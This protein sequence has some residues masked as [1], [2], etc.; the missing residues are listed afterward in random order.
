MAN[1][2]QCPEPCSRKELPH[3]VREPI[4]PS[5]LVEANSNPPSAASWDVERQLR[6]L[7]AENH[8]LRKAIEE[9]R[10]CVR[11]LEEKN[12][13]WARLVDECREWLE[14]CERSPAM[15]GQIQAQTQTQLELQL[16]RQE[17][18]F[19]DQQQLLQ[20]SE[21]AKR[22]LLTVL[23]MER[24]DYTEK[25]EALQ[26]ELRE[27]QQKREVELAA[28]VE[29]TKELEVKLAK[30]EDKVADL[31]ASKAKLLEQETELMQTLEKNAA[32]IAELEESDKKLHAELTE[33]HK[34]SEELKTRL[35]ETD[36]KAQALTLSEGRLKT[37][38]GEATKQFQQHSE[39]ISELEKLNGSVKGELDNVKQVAQELETRAAKSERRVAELE[40][41]QAR[42]E[43]DKQGSAAAL[44]LS[45]DRESALQKSLDEM[46]TRAQKA[47][48][49]AS[50]NSKA[51]EGKEAELA[52]TADI[53]TNLR[54][55]IERFKEGSAIADKELESCKLR[56]T[57]A[58]RKAEELEKLAQQSKTTEQAAQQRYEG[59]LASQKNFQADWDSQKLALEKEVQRL[60]Q[61]ISNL[62]AD[63]QQ[64]DKIQAEC[65][66]LRSHM[67]Q[68]QQE[69]MQCR[70]NLEV[71]MQASQRETEAQRQLLEANEQT[72]AL[73]EKLR[74]Q[75]ERVA[76]LERE[77]GTII[78]LAAG[79]SAALGSLAVA[80]TAGGGGSPAASPSA[81]V[82]GLWEDH[83]N[84]A[85][86]QLSLFKAQMVHKEKQT[87]AS[88]HLEKLASAQRLEAS[89]R[90]NA[91]LQDQ[92]EEMQKQVS[93]IAELE[94]K[95][96]RRCQDANEKLAS[97]TRENEELRVSAAV[98]EVKLQKLEEN[99]KAAAAISEELS[100]TKQLLEERNKMLDALHGQIASRDDALMAK[101]SELL[102]ANNQIKELDQ[103]MAALEGKLKAVDSSGNLESLTAECLELRESLVVLE[104]REKEKETQL[105]AAAAK[106]QDFDQTMAAMEERIKQE[107]QEQLLETQSQLAV[108]TDERSALSA[109]VG[110]LRLKL[111]KQ[112][113]EATTGLAAYRS[114]AERLLKENLE[115]RL[116]LEGKLLELQQ[117]Y[118]ADTEQLDQLE[119]DNEDLATRL[120]Q[121]DEALTANERE[122]STAIEAES[123]YFEQVQ[124]LETT[125]LDL[126][127]KMG[128]L[129][130][131]L[132]KKNDI[133]SGLE[134]NFAKER[135]LLDSKV[136]LVRSELQEVKAQLGSKDQVLD[137]AT[138]KLDEK[139]SELEAQCRREAEMVTAASGRIRELEAL[140]VQRDREVE[141][142]QAV[143]VQLSHLEGQIEK[144]RA[145][146]AQGSEAEARLKALKL[147][148]RA[149]VEHL[150][151]VDR[152]FDQV[153][154]DF[155]SNPSSAA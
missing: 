81:A 22:E 152:S 89:E 91:A 71:N 54:S 42:L 136:E 73:T 63:K 70:E 142:L 125:K 16:A 25:T 110:T 141:S 104:V 8:S 83:E 67:H 112:M 44:A 92:I 31:S 12:R 150:K 100:Q 90:H 143:R 153:L 93:H 144:E 23:G 79:R 120:E 97:F 98:S 39:R 36:A 53:V 129:Q 131:E 117:A 75:E 55:E 52:K 2:R 4:Q 118:D 30:T 45:Q 94:V 148:I 41:E 106:I 27:V 80:A 114:E 65:D 18:A 123:Q 82:G 3:R 57:E 10:R 1:S 105:K 140:L 78:A 145:A 134:S 151:E 111:A 85:A 95:L 113:D 130:A 115:H 59:A 62:E 17:A 66:A 24:R 56:C 96:E 50:T 32:R 154:K 122:L 109:E 146:A 127:E 51:L 43:T 49:E 124:E 72:K 40:Q 137:A 64:Q 102:A 61:H 77:R 99:L 21:E 60:Q 15:E 9:E 68:L 28:Q 19:H 119:R 38:E 11:Q 26:Q 33:A 135:G 101:E 84:S 86:M 35:E 46:T 149:Q 126:Q 155:T 7:R 13:D 20:R 138:R 29:A 108:L 69:T 48:T 147:T 14:Y 34:V 88:V 6:E 47:E 37:A 58:E 128:K 76:L 132:S 103:E 133:L 139:T 74:E 121:C 116:D 107:A 5:A 87:A